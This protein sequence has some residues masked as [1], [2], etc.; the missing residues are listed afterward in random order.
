MALVQVLPEG[1]SRPLLGLSVVLGAFGYALLAGAMSGALQA[2][3][4]EAE[5]MTFNMRL[6]FFNHTGL[7]I[8]TDV[9]GSSIDCL[10]STTAGSCLPALRWPFCLCSGR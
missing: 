5:H 7:A 2:L 8:G 10:G 1:L 3:I 4:P 9:A 6:S